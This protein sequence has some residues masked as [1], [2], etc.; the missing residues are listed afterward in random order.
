MDHRPYIPTSDKTIL[1]K[2]VLACKRNGERD[3]T[4]HKSGFAAPGDTSISDLL[5]TSI[6]A[7]V[8]GLASGDENSL[9][10]GLEMLLRG[11][12]MIRKLE[13]KI[14]INIKQKG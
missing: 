12:I 14:S 1:D 2:L 9:F 5:R 4:D 11:E 7:V 13:E 3:A 10:E 6:S 8:A